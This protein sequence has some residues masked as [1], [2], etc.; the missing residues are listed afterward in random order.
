MTRQTT[1]LTQL[2]IIALLLTILVGSPPAEARPPAAP[3]LQTITVNLENFGGEGSF[4]DG[5]DFSAQAVQRYGE[6]GP[7]RPELALDF[8]Y[9]EGYPIA[10]PIG[11]DIV[12]TI[13]FGAVGLETVTT[14]PDP[15]DPR[16]GQNTLS[17]GHTYGLYTLEGQ[18]VAFQVTNV[19]Q[20][21]YDDWH[22][23]G[24]TIVWKQL[25][26]PPVGVLAVTVDTY[27]DA[28]MWANTPPFTAW[29]RPMGSRWRESGLRFGCSTSRGTRFGASPS[30]PVRAA[31]TWYRSLMGKR[32]RPAIAAG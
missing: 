3:A 24:I 15:A 16:F 21:P 8:Y 19:Y 22:I 31:D 18:F 9:S 30:R 6:E 4:M 28:T 29:S 11:F 13:D 14:A 10:G 23:E 17:F 12:N 27:K 2:T 7:D 26:A 1:R 25:G 20:E 32:F 5:Y